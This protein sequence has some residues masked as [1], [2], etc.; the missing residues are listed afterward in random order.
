MKTLLPII[1][2]FLFDIFALGI[3]IALVI[4]LVKY[5]KKSKKQQYI[6]KQQTQDIKK[7]TLKE[8]YPNTT[9]SFEQQF[10]PQINKTEVQYDS[11][12]K[13]RDLITPFEKELYIILN[14]ILKDEKY[15][16]YTILSKIRMAD[17][18]ETINQNNYSDFNKIKSKHID[19]AL[20]DKQTLA[21]LLLI[22]LD[23]SSHNNPNRRNRDDF[24]NQSLVQ[25][26]YKIIHIR[27][28]DKGKIEGQI[29]EILSSKLSSVF[30]I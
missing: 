20:C 29:E 13:K 12:Y 7:K 24:V 28:L 6:K 11:T 4:F 14:E 18:I 25:A 15:N 9:F 2:M 22:E 23:D 19:F 27:N 21:P 10:Q 3:P 26:G 17:L 5:L 8:I 30:Y 16:N 1:A